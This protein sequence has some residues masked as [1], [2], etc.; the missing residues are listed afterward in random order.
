MGVP[1]FPDAGVLLLCVLCV[2]AGVENQNGNKVLDFMGKIAFEFYLIHGLFIELFGFNFI[3]VAPSLY[4]IRNV[5]LFV[6]VIVV[7]SI[8][9]TILLQKFHKWVVGLATGKQ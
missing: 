1:A 5:T 8:P 9:A 4:Y 3:D 2:Y 7:L 6:I